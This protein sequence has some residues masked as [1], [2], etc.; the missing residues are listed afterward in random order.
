MKCRKIVSL[1]LSLFALCPVAVNSLAWTEEEAHQA[2]GY[3]QYAALGR[4]M[5][6]QEDLEACRAMCE[7][8]VGELEQLRFIL[9]DF[10]EERIDRR[11]ANARFRELEHLLDGIPGLNTV[12]PSLTR[13]NDGYHGVIPYIDAHVSRDNIAGRIVYI[14]LLYRTIL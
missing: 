13:Y 6:T 8:I 4:D 10:T 12:I 9:Q 3:V 2:V 11:T 5:E 14:E 1:A 7:T